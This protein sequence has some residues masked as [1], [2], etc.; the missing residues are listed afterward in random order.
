M[1]KGIRSIRGGTTKKQKGLFSKKNS[2]FHFHLWHYCL[3]LLP[4]KTTTELPEQKFVDKA[5]CINM[6]KN[7]QPFLEMRLLCTLVEI[8]HRLNM[9]KSITF[10]VWQEV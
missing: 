1:Q 2:P 4:F 10:V 5:L 9:E 7:N 3:T 8:F 6:L